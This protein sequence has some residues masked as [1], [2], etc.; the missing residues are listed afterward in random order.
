M[1]LDASWTGTRRSFLDSSSSY[2]T[3][4]AFFLVCPRFAQT[5]LSFKNHFLHEMKIWLD[6]PPVDALAFCPRR[7]SCILQSK[8]ANVA[9]QFSLL[10]ESL[11][12]H[13]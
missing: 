8:C 4:P 1:E 7:Q 11:L 12:R 6:R 13:W 5:V 9:E 3:T 2:Q 10:K